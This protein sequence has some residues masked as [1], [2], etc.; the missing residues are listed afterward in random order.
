[1]AI[2]IEKPLVNGEVIERIRLLA[3]L[4]PQLQ[5][6]IERA[7]QVFADARPVLSK[8]SDCLRSFTG[9]GPVPQAVSGDRSENGS[10]PLPE[11]CSEVARTDVSLPCASCDSIGRCPE[12]CAKLE[13]FLG[14]VTKGRWVVIEL[15]YRQCLSEEQIAKKTGK[16]RSTVSGLLNRARERKEEYDKRLRQ[17]MHEQM[18]KEQNRNQGF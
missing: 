3:E 5:I 12:K 11:Q 17:E 16:A 10:S 15:Y 14:G 13:R 2:P 4:V 1:M 18:R 7:E 6:A 8:V 9:A